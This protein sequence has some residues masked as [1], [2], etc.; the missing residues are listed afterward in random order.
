MCGIYTSFGSVSKKELSYYLNKITQRGK[1]VFGINFINDTNPKS[2]YY[3]Y[4]NINFKECL[5][6]HNNEKNLI[7]ANA[8]LITNGSNIKN[9]QP[10]TSN[11]LSL[12]HNGIVVNFSNLQSN[13]I[14]LDEQGDSDTKILFNKIEKILNGQ[15]DKSKIEFFLNSLEG[16]INLIFFSTKNN[17]LYYYTN[18]GSLFVM[19]KGEKTIILSEK[20]F[21]LKKDQPQV[22]K[23]K[24]NILFDVSVDPNLKVENERNLKKVNNKIIKNNKIDNSLFEEVK[25]KI[26]KKICNI[27]RCKNCL[28]PITYPKL[29]FN[30]L[31]ICTFCENNSRI[32]HTPNQLEDLYKI[33]SN[34]PKKCLV[35]LSGGFDSCYTLYYVKEVLKLDP[36]AFTYDWGL[37]TDMARINQSITC[38]KL[39]VEHI[40]RTDNMSQKR[41]FITAN[42]NAWF[43]NPHPGLIPLFMA[44]DKKFLYFERKLKKELNI[45]YSFF[46]TGSA[47]ENRPFYYLFAGAS[48]D[49]SLDNGVM[50]SMKF[51]TKLKI[52]FFYGVNFLKNPKLINKSLLNSALAYYYSFF[53]NYNYISLF[54]Y[55]NIKDEEKNSFL[56]NEL[57]LKSDEKYGDEIWRMGDGQSSFNNLLYATL[58][59]FTEI[60]DQLS[61]AVRNKELLREKALERVL[62]HNLPKKDMLQYFFDLI[63]IDANKTL[64][65]VLTLN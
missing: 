53:E 51:E 19:N 1:D 2:F 18:C 33:I 40:I 50:S 57:G 28:I 10:L 3:S 36:I 59:G 21:F 37:T 24:N 30:E 27:K 32:K 46:G 25:E 58:C 54:K 62:K 39:K 26:K 43:E 17:K 52:L 55:L 20:S 14:E 4:E 49:G 6:F 44:G 29:E 9:S 23:V 65:K 38:Q 60:D 16:E 7:I 12:S 47:S 63:K 61:L 42:I 35:G 64:D 56:K 41:N 22:D 5:N 31:G 15:N 13:S 8:R 34:K 11:H 45:N 48:L